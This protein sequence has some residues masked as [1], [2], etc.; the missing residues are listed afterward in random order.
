MTKHQRRVHAYNDARTGALCGSVSPINQ[1]L[2]YPDTTF[3]C[4]INCKLC[5]A[6]LELQN[7]KLRAGAI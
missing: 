3:G 7:V 5:L 1:P 6:E 2:H 4:F